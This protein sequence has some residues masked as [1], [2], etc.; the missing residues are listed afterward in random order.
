MAETPSTVYL[1]VTPKIDGEALTQTVRDAIADALES[2]AA[3]LR[4]D[5]K[6]RYIVER[7]SSDLTYGV[8]DRRNAE[9]APFGATPTDPETW[10]AKLN[11]GE[12]GHEDLYWEGGNK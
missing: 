7:R 3:E 4:G 1:E 12:I 11:S 2:V 5:G 9:F 8:L 6:P 10:A